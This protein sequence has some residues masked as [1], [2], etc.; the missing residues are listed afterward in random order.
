MSPIA[1]LDAS[2]G[3]PSAMNAR[4][5]TRFSIACNASRMF[6]AT[7]PNSPNANSEKAI[8]TTPSTL[9]SGARRNAEKASRRA[10][11]AGSRSYR[12]LVVM[13][14]RLLD[15]W[16]FRAVIHETPVVQLDRAVFSAPYQ[17]E[18]VGRHD[19]RGAGGIDV[20]QKLEDAACRALIQIPSGLVRDQHERIVHESARDCHSLLLPARQLARERCP[21]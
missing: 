10:I 12:V 18:I 17:V 15:R 2:T 13:T 9:S 4:I 8:V 21:L 11:I 20:A 14:W 16:G 19:D 1:V 5:S 6:T 7:S 3:V